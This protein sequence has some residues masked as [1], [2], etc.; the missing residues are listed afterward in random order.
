MGKS[1]VAKA[2]THDQRRIKEALAS[3][4]CPK[5]CPSNLYCIFVCVSVCLFV[6]KDLKVLQR[7]YL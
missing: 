2:K 6:S 3:L 7:G 4:G 1:A 5:C